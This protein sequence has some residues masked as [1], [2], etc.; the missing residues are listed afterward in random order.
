MKH[1]AYMAL[2]KKPDGTLWISKTPWKT[3]RR[4]PKLFEYLFIQ[5]NPPSDSVEMQF[6]EIFHDAARR[7]FDSVNKDDLRLCSTTIQT[8]GVF[9]SAIQVTQP[10]VRRWFENFK[11]FEAARWLQ[12][13]EQF[14]EDPVKYWMPLETEVEIEVLKTGQKLHIDRIGYYDKFSLIVIDYKSGK[15]FDIRDL[16]Q[17]LTFYS[18]GVNYSKRY[19]L[20]VI[21]LGSYNP[22]LNLSYLERVNQR[23]TSFVY[24]SI[25]KF[26][27]E[28]KVGAY[29]AK[30]SELC[31][32]CPRVQLC[33]NEG[34]FDE[35]KVE[36]SEEDGLP[37]Q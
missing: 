14:P 13:L 23:S 18:I 3:W 22:Q 16:R 11:M 28:M 36:D 17:E 10:V 31:R 30:P 21:W 26:K 12:C 7:F 29:I 15:T 5:N 19:E 1:D 20:P 8:L 34:V 33:V 6:G 37:N 27:A 35:P 4:C 32:W 25:Q 9:D 2:L 24:R